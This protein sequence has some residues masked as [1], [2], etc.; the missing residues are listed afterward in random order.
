MGPPVKPLRFN[1]NAVCRT[2]SRKAA[3][4]GGSTGVPFVGL[5]VLVTAGTLTNSHMPQR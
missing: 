3:L 4:P 1:R 5:F 2:Y